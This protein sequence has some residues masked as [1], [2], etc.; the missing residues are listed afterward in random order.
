MNQTKY[1]KPSRA[2]LRLLESKKY[3]SIVVSITMQDIRKTRPNEVTL[4]RTSIGFAIKE[5]FAAV[6]I[7]ENFT[8]G[9]A[10]LEHDEIFVNIVGLRNE[11]VSK[12]PHSFRRFI[13]SK[14]STLPITEKLIFRHRS[15]DAQREV[16]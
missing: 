11:L 8:A 1:L 16:A 13:E 6:G 12:L 3:I 5:A 15:A 7:A 4:S 14:H 10:D 9:A 2:M